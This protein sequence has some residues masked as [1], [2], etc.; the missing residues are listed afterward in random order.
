M[1]N[2]CK[3]DIYGDKMIPHTIEGMSEKLD[4]K[5]G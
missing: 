5:I 3:G 4:L 2:G 1:V